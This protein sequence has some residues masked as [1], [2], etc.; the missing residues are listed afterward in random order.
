MMNWLFFAVI[1]VFVLCAYGGYK[2]GFISVVMSLVALL[3]AFCLTTAIAPK[4]GDYL[5][6]ESGVYETL[7]KSTYNSIKNQ[8]VMQQTINN[9]KQEEG[10]S[11]DGTSIDQFGGRI[12]TFLNEV[13]VQLPIPSAISK[14][15]ISSG[16]GSSVSE[17]I[18]GAVLTIE[19]TIMSMIADKIAALICNAAAYVGVF[20]I[21]YIII[22]IV[23]RL[24]NIVSKMPVINEVN[25]LFGL[26]SG[27]LKGM[28]LI[29]LFFF[30]IT[31]LYNTALAQNVMQCVEGNSFLSFLYNSN[32]FMKILIASAI[33]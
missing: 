31:M 3:A 17:G 1:G 15:M 5:K 25:K 8:E 16:I 24:V 22:K 11:V 7:R 2:R 21:V 10:I 9:V 28:L 6:N 32:V 26:V 29:W 20:L 30:V 19:E 4:V 18:N 13:I 14:Q 23:L 12:D 33:R 27:L